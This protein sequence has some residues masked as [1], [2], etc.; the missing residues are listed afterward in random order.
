MQYV[1][2]KTEENWFKIWR[3]RTRLNSIMAVSVLQAADVAVNKDHNKIK[4][5]RERQILNQFSSFFLQ[6]IAKLFK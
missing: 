5:R 2:E 1:A 3:C 4:C 6:H